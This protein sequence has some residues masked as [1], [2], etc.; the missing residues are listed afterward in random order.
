MCWLTYITRTTLLYLNCCWICCCCLWRLCNH[1]HHHLNVLNCV[2]FSQ[3]TWG[4]RIVGKTWCITYWNTEE[5][6]RP[7][8]WYPKYIN[9][10]HILAISVP[11]LDS[12]SV[13]K[14]MIYRRDRNAN[15]RFGRFIFKG[16]T[17]CQEKPRHYGCEIV[18]INSIRIVF[19][20]DVRTVTFKY[21]SQCHTDC[22][23]GWYLPQ[24]IISCFKY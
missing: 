23:G 14:T 18:C 21:C 19:H 12:N 3:K 20:S 9:R 15:V 10:R 8:N 17:L 13:Y 16:W 1:H 22:G 2:L 5:M 6:K 7:H 24:S 11:N 4:W